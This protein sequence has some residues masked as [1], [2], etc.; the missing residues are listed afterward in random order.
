MPKLTP[1]EIRRKIYGLRDKI[2]ALQHECEHPET[3]PVS[4]QPEVFLGKKAK[5][6]RCKYCDRI[7]RKN[8]LEK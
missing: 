5:Y 4:L 1:K 8:E 7:L 6:V 2:I 3:G